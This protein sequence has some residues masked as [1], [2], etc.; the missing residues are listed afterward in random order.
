MPVSSRSSYEALSNPPSP[1]RSCARRV[2]LTMLHSGLPPSPVDSHGGIFD[3]NSATLLEEKR[4]TREITRG[5]PGDKKRAMDIRSPHERDLARKRSQYYEN[6]FAVDPKPA[7]TA[8]DRVLRESF[9]MAEIKTNVIINDEYS[10]ITDI[11]YALSTRYQRPENS[12]L[13]TLS[14]SCCVLFGGNS[15]PAYMLNVTALPSQVLPIT[16]RRNAV[17]LAKAMEDALGVSAERGIIKF[18]S[19][20]EDSLAYNGRTVGREIEEL[21][22]SQEESRK[23]GRCPSSRGTICS[24]RKPSIKS[25]RGYKAHQL[26][27]HD[28][29][30]ISATPK[31]LMSKNHNHL[32]I[33]ERSTGVLIMEHQNDRFQKMGRRRS[34][35]A[36]IFGKT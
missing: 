10:L 8:R 24:R 5:T 4:L 1:T 29:T 7:F 18:T 30:M 15:E 21:E 28:E 20:S 2:K 12:I 23:L 17:L 22:R 25:I 31:P 35:I 34:F 32:S 16:N 11:S 13:V 33:P 26:H 27:T 14:H 36:S 3:Q 9:I 6:A 19:I